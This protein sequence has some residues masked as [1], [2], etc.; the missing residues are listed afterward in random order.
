MAWKGIYLSQAAYLSL[1][2]HNLQIRF[3][4]A[5]EGTPQALSLPLEDLDYLIIDTPEVT[6]SSPVIGALSA[7]SVLLMGVDDRH[8]PHWASFPWAGYYQQGCTLELQLEV[9]QPFQKQLWAHIVRQK[10]NEQAKC[11]ESTGRHDE[12]RYLQAISRQVLSGDTGNAEARAARLYWAALF[13]SRSFI[14][15]A[16]DLP[17]AILNYGYALIRAA[18]ARNLCAL[19]FIP[20]LGLHHRSKGNAFNLADDL[21]EPYRPLIDYR[22]V[23]ILGSQPSDGP[24]TKEHRKR[25]VQILSESVLMNGEVIAL[26]V[27]IARTVSGLRHALHSRQTEALVFPTFETNLQSAGEEK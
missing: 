10:I 14:R 26:T 12:A 6:L 22:A 21:I 19:G 7:A 3:R 15:H 18:I 5:D 24:F 23:Q 13:D 27:G 17:N 4:H 11:L 2:H 9:S 20:Q 16:D 8:Q 25:L 1:S